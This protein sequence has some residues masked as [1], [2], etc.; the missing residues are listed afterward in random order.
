M[1]KTRVG[2][3]EN[4]IVYV[5]P[6]YINSVEEYDANGL[7][8]Y[9]FTPPLEDYCVF[10]NLEV[11][12]RGRNVQTSKSSNGKTM[13]L[14]YMTKLDGDSSINFMQGSKVPIGESGVTMN[15]L[16]TNYT[17]IYLGDLKKNGPSTEMFGINSIDIAY[18]S[19]MVPEVTIE[20]TDI[21][22]VALFAQK[23]L[24]ESSLISDK[25]INGEK[26]TD[27]ANTFF[28][29]FFTFP[30]PK[31]RLYVK[32]FYG[33]PV[34]YELTCADFR[35][36]FDSKTG[37]FGCTAKFVGYHFSFLNDVM[38]NGLVAAPY[39]DYIGAKYWESRKF[40]ITGTSENEIA[41]PKIGWLINKMKDIESMA[42]RISQ[43]DPTA[44]E[45]VTLDKKSER[46]QNIEIAYSNYAREISRIV[47]RKYSEDELKLMY[48]SVNSKNGVPKSS[49]I[50]IADEISGDDFEDCFE[51]T[52][53]LDNYYDTFVEELEK[54]N[55]EFPDEKLPEVSKFHEFDSKQRIFSAADKK[56]VFM[57]DKVNDDIK[58]DNEELYNLFK[59]GVNESNKENVSRLLNNKYAYYFYDNGFVNILES[60]KEANGERTKEVEKEIEKLHDT[61]VSKALGFHPTVEN[62][63]KIVMAHFETFARMIFETSKIICGQKPARTIES[64]RVGDIRDFSDIKNKDN[65]KA[66]IVPPFPKVTTEV[67]R[68]NSTIREESWVGNYE[69]DFREK[70][71]VHGIINGVKEIAKD[72]QKY[73]DSE[74]AG[75]GGGSTTSNTSVTKYPLTPLDMIADSKPYL[76]GILDSNDLPNVLGLVGLRAVQILS[77]TNF[78]D[79][80]SQATALGEAEAYNF[81]SNNKVNKDFSEKISGL[82][83]DDI[84]EMMMGSEGRI[85]KTGDSWPW[86]F[87]GEANRGIINADGSLNICFANSGFTIPYQ[88]LSWSKINNETKQSTK[89]HYSND[90]INTSPYRDTK[91]NRVIAKENSFT[92][93]TNINRFSTI[94]ESQLTGIDNIGYYQ[95]KFLKECKY[96]STFYKD[97]CLNDSNAQNIIAYIIENASAITPS[98]GSCMLPTSKNAFSNESFEHGYNMNYFNKEYPGNGGSGQIWVKGWKDK[99]GNDV[100]RKGSDGYT[101]Y[102][103]EFNYRDFTFTEFP[104][105]DTDL[106]PNRDVSIFGELLYYWQKDVKAKALLFLASL[107]YAINYHKIILQFICNKQRTMQV[108][109]LP[110][111]LFAGALLWAETTSEGKKALSDGKITT[112]HYKDQVDALKTLN[113]SVIERLMGIFSNWINNGIKNDSLLRSFNEM[114]EGLE[115]HLIHKDGNKER[116]YEEFFL[117]IP[118]IEDNG[119]FGG[120]NED[121]KKFDESYN[122]IMDF[123][124]GELD[125]N[126][127][128]NYITIDE[129]SKGSSEDGTIGLRLGIRDG[130]P[131]AI[132][133]C[134]FAL[135]GCIF[136][137]NS[138]YFN[139]TNDIVPKADTGELIQFFN[140]FLSV[141]QNIKVDSDGVSTQISQAK[142]PDD[143]NDDIKIGIYRYCKMIYDKWIAGISEEEFNKSLTIEAFFDDNREDKYFYFIDAYYNKAEFIKI[144]IG[145]F[146]DRV[147]SCY[148]NEQFSLLSFLSGLYQQNKLNFLCVQNFIDLGDKKNLEKMFDTISFNEIRYIKDHPNFIVMYPYESSNYLDIENSEYEN[149]GF[150]INQP[151]S[152]TNKWP[153]ALTSRNAN[154]S[155]RYNIPAF[156]VSYGKMYQSY[157]KDVDVSMDSPIVTEQS[158][159][160]QFAIACQNN[161]GEQTGDRSKIYTYGQDLFSIYSN[162]SYTCTVTMMGCAWVQPLMYFVL[163][164]VPMFRGT[165]L[166]EKVSHHI[167]PGNMVTKFVGVRMSNVCTRIA[168]EDSIRERNNQTGNGE[169]NG[170]SDSVSVKELTAGVA[171]NCP[172]KVYPLVID[173]GNVKLSGSEKDSAKSLMSKLISFGYST[174]AAAGI[175]GN[176]WE[177]SL[178][179][180]N[181]LIVDSNGYK[182]GGL[183]MW[184]A[185]NLCDLVNGNPYGTA[186]DPSCSRSIT[187]SDL[188][189]A[190]KQLEFLH[191]SIIKSYAKI[192]NY[193]KKLNYE[194]WKQFPGK[195]LKDLLN[196]AS[197]AVE[198]AK[199]FA[200]VYERCKKCMQGLAENDLRIEKAKAYFNA[201]NSNTSSTAPVARNAKGK[202]SDLATA[203]LNSLN[204]TSSSSS[205]KVNIGIKTEKSDGDTI[206]LTNGNNSSKFGSVLDMILSAYSDKVDTINW[207]LPGDG[208]SQHVLPVAFLVHVKE[209]STYKNIKVTSE[210]NPSQMIGKV[211]IPKGENNNDGIHEDFCYALVK[212]Y[213]SPSQQLKGDTNNQL[214]NYEALFEKYK[215]E[216]CSSIMKELGMED[217]INGVGGVLQENM[218]IGNW[219]A[220]KAAN[221]L[222]QHGLSESKHICAFAVQQAVLAGGIE[223]P[224]GNGYRKALNMVNEGGWRFELTGKTD[225]N[226]FKNYK[227]EVGDV[228]GMTKGSDFNYVGHVC[229]YCGDGNGWYSDFKQNKPYVYGNSGPGTFWIIKYNGNGKSTNQKPS[230]CYNGK[231]L[232]S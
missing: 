136:S 153:E 100:K 206:W 164:N 143:S 8:T 71:L 7:N 200:A 156:G 124:K 23:E 225:S 113:R 58:S 186:T 163:N 219:D 159:K 180:A 63:T 68:E 218:K 111:V 101:K 230:T 209:G 41:M 140:G 110:A 39:S 94:A 154:S 137:K 87:N 220:G 82:N 170:N 65:D 166:I 210:N 184:N 208:S 201:Y 123:L 194:Y 139:E 51:E 61:A 38:M 217:N 79:W 179:K 211:V 214:D 44:Q 108:I 117:K 231:C 185:T 116:T 75:N 215:I 70:D 76:D 122:S 21:R 127:F 195:N 152:T 97:N 146:C 102:L 126:F 60:Y 17:D 128:R 74:G 10:V 15:S 37:N 4:N 34:S 212:A 42:D 105:V 59:Q 199:I 189:S 54:Y 57:E 35:G 171:N 169:E 213:G 36:R 145:D 204:K 141:I 198:A 91:S 172:Y 26:Y 193:N 14:S 133:A 173:D 46:Y 20:F 2:R 228:M 9:E 5:E 1:G 229:M 92:Y 161:T 107:G 149:D 98:N 18:N 182:S 13:V 104:G 78:Q 48:Y 187:S 192:P 121:I 196:N 55:S 202:V 160:A 125:D 11:E 221:F 109:P 106:E 19:Y 144:N 3:I 224:S 31:F 142:E 24:Y 222:I 227:P 50:L 155:T 28:Q 88:N 43:S 138:K 167:E 135:A 188:P 197:S 177:E 203:F 85:R 134:N 56:K 112:Y 66:T 96:S 99:D 226:E 52:S 223:C 73:E 22:G 29:C 232:R 80:G 12:T 131:S 89:S 72:I 119:V 183:C 45:K 115:L 147:V 148:R 83:G 64:L 190:D 103:E 157:F 178:F 25:A 181:N 174:S 216:D 132:H 120:K 114:R 150:M 207:I 162:N 86:Q 130:G 27:I 90:Y 67:K 62:I 175:V 191:N 165:Y 47:K 6:N 32:G 81:L 33:N 158:I 176:M 77:T 168:R 40:K 30:Y 53:Q 129:D 49:I 84:L 95:E 205:N 16:T 151:P 118:E 69:G 93:D